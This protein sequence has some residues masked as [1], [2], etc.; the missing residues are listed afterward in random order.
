MTSVRSPIA[1]AP[2]PVIHV[3]FIARQPALKSI[4]WANVEVALPVTARYPLVVALP[5][6]SMVKSVEEALSVISN[7]Y[8]PVPIPSA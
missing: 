1:L 3:P 2:P 8:A 6:S 7:T 5:M 4:P